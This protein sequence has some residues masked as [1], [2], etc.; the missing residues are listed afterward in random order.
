MAALQLNPTFEKA[1][2]H[3][4]FTLDRA[5]NMSPM[6]S[7]SHKEES[8]KSEIREQ[9]VNFLFNLLEHP[10]IQRDQILQNI[11]QELID[12][13]VLSLIHI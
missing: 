8:I 12:Q 13:L 2:S 6:P 3:L 11:L 1:Q 9:Y 10:E 7:K 4:H 5:Y